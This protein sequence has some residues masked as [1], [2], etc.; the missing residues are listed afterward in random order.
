MDTTFKFWPDQASSFAKGVDALYIFLLLVTAFFTLLI[1]AMILYLGLKYRRRSNRKP[2]PAKTSKALEAT[3][4][5][6]PLVLVLVM[7]FWGAALFIHIERPPADAMVIDVIGRQW[8]WKLQ[9][10]QGR[11]EINELH[12]PNDRPVKL[13]MTSQDVIHS[14]YI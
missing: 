13:N 6:I 5:I 12:V 10:P 3:W 4:T 7:F 1:S 2:A 9:H 14:F 11:R 8:M